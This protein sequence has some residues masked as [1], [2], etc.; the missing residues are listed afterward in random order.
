[1]KLSFRWY[2]MEDPVRLAYIRTGIWETLQKTR[3]KEV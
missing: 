1:M 2:G 3:K